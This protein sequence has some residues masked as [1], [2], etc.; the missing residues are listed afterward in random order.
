MNLQVDQFEPRELANDH[1]SKCLEN[2]YK[3][4]SAELLDNACRLLASHADC[5]FLG[6]RLS[7]QSAFDFRQGLRRLLEKY[8]IKQ[9]Q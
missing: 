3:N 5:H 6:N 8:E 7:K 1:N 2:C 9:K 4:A